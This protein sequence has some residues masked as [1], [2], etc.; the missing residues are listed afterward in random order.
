MVTIDDIREAAARL[1]GVAVKT[2]LLEYPLLN[3]RVGR[4]VLL[5][6]ESL[7][8]TGSFKIRGA[9]NRIAQMTAEER[10]R[11]LI[12]WSS[13]NHAQGVAR[14]AQLVGTPAT[15]LM[16]QDAPAAKIEGTRRFGAEIIHFDRYTEDREEI[17]HRLAA[18]RGL[19][20]VPSYDDPAV[21]AGQGTCGLEIAQQAKAAGVEIDQLLVCAGGGGLTAGCA[22]AFAA[23]MPGAKVYTVEPE[24]YDDIALSLTK[25]ERV[26]VD[27]GRK[28][29]A[30]ALLPPT[31]GALTWPILKELVAGGL[32]VTEA[33]IRDAVRF[34][35]RELNLKLEPGGAAALAA[36]L[37]G[38]VE[39]EGKVTAVTLTGGNVDAETFAALTS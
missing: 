11:G 9:Y 6:A 21:I 4:R 2:P 29:I 5:K 3:E 17:G 13:G 32:A 35:F 23:E 22:I 20:L 28:S 34:G 16:P 26:R 8:V 25:G 15:I 12:A 7:Q 27:V 33:Q 38:A 18:E 19:V 10:A 14:A 24:G 36:V 37:A 1:S 30:D 39:L 31:P